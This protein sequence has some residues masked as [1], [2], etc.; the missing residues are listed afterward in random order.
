MGKTKIL[1]VEDERIIGEDLKRTL[2]GLEYEVTNVVPT[3]ED[4]LV[5]LVDNF[6]DVVLMD[7]NLAGQMSG[8]ETAS[9]V[10]KDFGIPVIYVTAYAD[11]ETLEK[12]RI[13]EPYGYILKPFE[14]RELNAAID[15][16]LY[17]SKMNRL[18]KNNEL[19]LRKV[20]DHNPNLI[21]IKKAAGE[22]VLINRKMAD[23]FNLSPAE[24]IGKTDKELAP[25]V[26]FDKEEIDK[27]VDVSD[28]KK[29]SKEVYLMFKNQTKRWYNITQIPLIYQG[30]RHILGIMID[31]TEL[32]IAQYEIS[33]K[34]QRLKKL[35]E[36]TVNELQNLIK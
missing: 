11:K 14:E 35:I 8:I 19:L 2:V 12:A 7:I 22:Y 6:P 13:T 36:S 27:F 18:L 15:M 25:N 28:K 4:A 32:K 16:A 24:I 29:V 17:K 30:N 23:F 21:Y 1:I 34:N 26:L 5:S 20:I 31:I 33:Q 10:K 9:K 3:G